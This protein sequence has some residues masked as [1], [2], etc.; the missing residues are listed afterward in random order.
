MVATLK[1]LKLFADKVS[2]ATL[3]ENGVLLVSKMM[4]A[5]FHGVATSSKGLLQEESNLPM[6]HISDVFDPKAYK[7]MEESRYDFNKSPSPKHVIGAKPYGPNDV[8]KNGAEI[9]RWN[10]NTTDWSW[11]H[12]TLTGENFKTG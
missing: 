1:Y 7:L 6:V 12:A 2:W 11:L 10:C 3:I 8:E 9:G 4:K 5:P